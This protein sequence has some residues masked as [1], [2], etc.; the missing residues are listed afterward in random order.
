[1]SLSMTTNV[2]RATE[3]TVDLPLEQAMAL[4]TPEGET[5]LGRRL[6]ILTIRNLDA[7]KA[8]G[9]C[10]LPGTAVIKRPGSWSTTDPWACATR[11]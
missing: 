11:V 1:M 9:P 5:P 2:R 8:Q 4:F 3:I 10:S 6:G 7:A